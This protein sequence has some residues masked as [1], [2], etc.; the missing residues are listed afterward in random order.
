VLL[1][2]QAGLALTAPSIAIAVMLPI[3]LLL[4]GAATARGPVGCHGLC[5]GHGL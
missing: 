2:H 5:F 3:G 1:H 4:F